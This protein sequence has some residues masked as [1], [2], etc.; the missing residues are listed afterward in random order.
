MA[1][2]N[3]NANDV[4]PNE[5]REVLPAGEYD[6]AITASEAYTTQSGKMGGLKL[7]MQVLNGAFQNRKLWDRIN[8]RGTPGVT[9]TEGEAKAVAIGAGNL[10]SLCRAVNVLTP[11]D[12]SELHGRAFRV[13]VTVKQSEEF[14]PQN[15]IA[16][17]K[18]RVVGGTGPTSAQTPVTPVAVS[19]E[20]PW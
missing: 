1:E 10:S 2:M 6:V 16:A 14:G 15:N 9:L 3:F 17:Y 11:K 7:E 4:P 19:S 13:K 20:V 8:F 5:P 12:S 18:P